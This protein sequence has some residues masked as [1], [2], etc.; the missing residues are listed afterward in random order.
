MGT[1][2]FSYVGLLWLILLLVPNLAWTR[3]RPEGDAPRPER[4]FL[5]ILE[6]AA[7]R[8]PPAAL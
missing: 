6:G 7:R 5:K 3:A 1:F 2:G 8:G 4:R